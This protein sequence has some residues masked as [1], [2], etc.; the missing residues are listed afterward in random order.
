MGLLVPSL[1]HTTY[2]IWVITGIR[3]DQIFPPV[4]G[5]RGAIDMRKLALAV[6]VATAEAVI[7]AS[8][9]AVRALRVDTRGGPN[10]SEQLCV[11]KYANEYG[12]INTDGACCARCSARGFASFSLSAISDGACDQRST[13][14]CGGTGAGAKTIASECG[15]PL[16]KRLVFAVT[17]GHTGSNTLSNHDVNTPPGEQSGC[18]VDRGGA[19][20]PPIVYNFEANQSYGDGSVLRNYG[21]KSWYASLRDASD[22]AETAAAR[23][24]ARDVLIP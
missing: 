19:A 9:E 14:S 18:Y 10:A 3:W 24:I 15:R 8:P 7:P 21:L 12:L 22:L 4:V 17:T 11:P 6:G 20:A 13:C 1:L 2:H 23:A 16:P 5:A